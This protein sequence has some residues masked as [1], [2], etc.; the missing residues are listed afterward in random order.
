MKLNKYVSIIGRFKRSVRIDKDSDSLEAL[1]GYVCIPSAKNVI[2]TML[3]QIKSD[4][5]GAFT[6]TGPYGSGKSSLAVVL[7]KFVSGRKKARIAAAKLVDLDLA[8]ETWD[9]LKPKKEGWKVVSVVGQRHDPIKIIGDILSKHNIISKNECGYTSND[10]VEAIEKEVELC[11][12]THGGLLLIVD[13]MGKFLEA[14]ASED[15]D[16]HLFQELAELSSR[17]NGKFVF[18]GILHQAVQEYARRM[19][20]NMRDEWMKIHGRFSDLPVS[21]AGEEQLELLARAIKHDSSLPKHNNL[22]KFFLGEIKSKLSRISSDLK[23]SFQSCFPLHPVTAS[24]LGPISR[25][26]FGQSQRSLFAFLNSSEPF[27]FQDFLATHVKNDLYTPDLLWDYLKFNLEPSILASSDGHKWAVAAEAIDRCELSDNKNEYSLK[28]LKSIA[29]IDLFK[30]G[31][32]ITASKKIISSCFQDIAT[33]EV[34]EYCK[35]L[36]DRSFVIFRSFISS[37]GIFSGSDFDI[38]DALNKK[39]DEID[40]VDF[41]TIKEIIKTQPILAKRFYHETGAMYWLDYQIC[42]IDQMLE[43]SSVF[44]T[45]NDIVGTFIVG[46]PTNGETQRE[47]VEIC[48]KASVINKSQSCLVT[49]YANKSKNIILLAKELLALEKIQT[50]HSELS[51]D[52]VARRE[53]RTRL[54][55]VQEQLER[56]LEKIFSNAIWFKNS[57]EIG[58]RSLLQ[59]SKLASE[60]VKA[61][62]PDSPIIKNE[63][64]NRIKPSPSAVGAKHKLLERMIEKNKTPNLGIEGSSTEAG[65]YYAILQNTG[66]YESKSFKDLS[67][68]KNHELG[69]DKLWKVARKK[70]KESDKNLLSM[71]DIF[72]IWQK[73][74]F[75]VKG[76]LLE[77]LGVSFMLSQLDKLAIYRDGIFQTGLTY[78]DVEYLCMKPSSIQLRWME[79]STSSKELLTGLA[80]LVRELDPEIKLDNLTSIDVARGLVSIFDSF[81]NWTMRTMQLSQRAIGVRL[82]LK[83]ANDPNKLLFESIPNIGNSDSSNGTTEAL[84]RFRDGIL[85]LKNSYPSLLKR[86]KSFL[87]H[88]L[89]VP[90]DTSA[91]L[92]EL[93]IRAKNIAKL[94]GDFKQEAFNNRLAVFSGKLK[95]VEGIISL[96]VGRPASKWLDQD[97]D[98]GEIAIASMARNFLKLE[99]F[100][101]VKGRK[102]KRHAIGL[103]LG[104][105]NKNEAIKIDFEVTEEERAIANNLSKSMLESIPMEY[106]QNKRALLTALSQIALEVS[107]QLDNSNEKEIEQCQ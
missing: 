8:Q 59:L 78:L 76:G 20:R 54:I 46:I 69:L 21:A 56:S 3:N 1:E 32:I 29:V 79:L 14:V 24:L 82:I 12:K 67:K 77:I 97:I 102:N 106:K 92:K 80:E 64:L 37:Y 31:S 26:K 87:L 95:E 65:L 41:S 101:S 35:D 71:Q 50:E 38:E 107:H 16:I 99:T 9:I 84:A 96:L 39:M 98:K 6:W 63:L 43:N 91:A 93:N 19:S 48:K 7:T 74:P 53:V 85:E 66:I 94:S 90:N 104:L 89:N 17:S 42:P 27:G 15:T 40:T 60:I 11:E 57:K 58:K 51:G 34:E 28:I 86:L 49:A 22:L 2:L 33:D 23:E 70:L 75:G 45:S 72:D 47:I 44:E 10:I 62:F 55:S 88:E 83:K 105:D 61:K 5:Q 68:S 103:V 52:P 73:P 100:A 4:K 30:S 13:E 25:R 36:Q 18:V 81:S